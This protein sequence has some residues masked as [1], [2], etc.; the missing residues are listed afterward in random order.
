MIKKIVLPAAG[1]G[2][3]LLPVTKEMPKE[4]LP[5]FALDTHSKMCVKPLL[6]I[7]FEQFYDFGVREFCFVVGRG[8]KSIS[9]HFTSDQMYLRA[10]IE[11][12][13]QKLAKELG[14]FYNKIRSSS[15]VYV[16]QPE[17]KGFGDAVLRAEPYVNEPFLV[18]AGDTLIL[19]KKNNHLRRLLKIH[20][21]YSCSATFFVQEVGDPRPFGIIEGKEIETGV[22]NVESLFEKPEKPPTNLAI[23]ALYA[24]D[25]V[26]FKALKD[27]ADGKA[28]ELQLTDGIQKLVHNGLKVMAIKLAKDE[29][30]LDIGNPL[31]YWQALSNSYGFFKTMEQSLTSST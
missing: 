5:I 31:S 26:I 16:S 2:T 22:F 28:G 29:L 21:K 10:L 1:G 11:R 12:D 30:W 25:T 15:L 23:S 9:D 17:P 6:Q 19:S 18:Q 7:V 13:K 27:T 20:E 24:F 3:R 8:K 14:G 4:M